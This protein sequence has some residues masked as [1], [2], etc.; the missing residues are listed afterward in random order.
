M[1]AEAQA[2]LVAASAKEEQEAAAPPPDPWCEPER[3]EDM[4]DQY[5]IESKFAGRCPGSTCYLVQ[6]RKRDGSL[7]E[8]V[9]N[10]RF[11]LFLAPRI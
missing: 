6:A 1:A 8:V 9:E 5:I 2:A 11:K 10:Q 7:T 3:L 4:L